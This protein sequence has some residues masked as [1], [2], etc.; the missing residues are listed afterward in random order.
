MKIFKLKSKLPLFLSTGI[1]T[2]SA[3][4]YSCT[5]TQ[6]TS[7]HN[8]NSDTKKTE[9]CS[10]D[11]S[12]QRICKSERDDTEVIPSCLPKNDSHS[13]QSKYQNMKPIAEKNSNHK[14]KY[15]T[16]LK[17]RTVEKSE[18]ML[19]WV[20]V[21]QLPDFLKGDKRS[22][23]CQGNYLE[24]DW[25][26]RNFKGNSNEAPVIAKADHYNY[27]AEES[28]F[29][30]NVHIEQGNRLIESDQAFFDKK[31]NLASLKGHVL[32]R[33]PGILIIGSHGK[34]NT[35][36]NTVHIN[37][38]QYVL[39]KKHIR[40]SA[41]EVTRD[42]NQVLHF[43][44]AVYT[45]AP[46]HNNAWALKAKKMTINPEAGWGSATD[47]T[48]NIANTPVMYTPYI[49]FPVD[50]RRKTGSLYPE[51]SLSNKRGTEYFQPFYINIAPN[52][53]DTI[54][55]RIMTR[56]GFMLSN[57]F[58]YLHADSQGD[59]GFSYLFGKDALKEKNPFYNR[60]RW[61]LFWKHHHQLTKN[62]DADIDYNKSADKN[63]LRDFGMN[64]WLQTDNNAETI[65]QKLQLR[66]QQN[67]QDHRW[68]F[69]AKAHQFQNMVLEKNDAYSRLPQLTL[70]G[71]NKLTQ[72]LSAR[73]L[74]DYT[75]FCRNKDWM[76]VDKTELND[77]YKYNY[78]PGTGL[79]N[80]QGDRSYMEGQLK[81]RI[82]RSYGFWESGAIYKGTMYSLKSL[83]LDEVRK[84]LKRPSLSETSMNH[85]KMFVPSF[86]SGAGLFFDRL[87]SYDQQNYKQTL[88]PHVQYVYTP[89]VKNQDKIP[90]FDTSETIFNYGNLYNINRFN[91]YD[92]I[93]DTNHIAA[94]VT[95][96][97]LNDQGA[98]KFFFGLG[99]IYYL[100]NRIA[101]INPEQ[102][103]TNQNKFINKQQLNSRIAEAY[104]DRQSPLATKILWHMTPEWSLS[105]DYVHN[106]KHNRIDQ[107]TVG[108]N[109]RFKHNSVF[110]IGYS[111]LKQP[112][113]IV[114]TST[115]QNTGKQVNGDLN[116]AETSFA[117]PLNS[118]TKLKDSFKIFG[119]WSYDITN[120][121][122]LNRMTG[123]QADTC[124]YQIRLVYRSYVNTT[125][126]V[127][128][129]KK[130]HGIFLQFVLK[131]LGDVA[132]NN[133][134]TI[135][136]GIKG[137]QPGNE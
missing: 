2:G 127:E 19:D 83:H 117:L 135:L 128:V 21:N 123:I 17:E 44:D 137:Y 129:A 87:F 99:Q 114:L 66:Y 30:G 20:S 113:R 35:E 75:R 23:L 18:N 132:G 110:N 25:S 43:K 60:H 24:P 59:T 120:K 96:R 85:P 73:Y 1:L 51:I 81:Y 38:V 55:P 14:K 5:Y 52:Y 106:L 94:G 115:G 47:A 79:N 97:I 86:Y 92:R 48:L 4:F 124:N 104:Q 72:Q 53:D 69:V 57:Q 136:K 89:Y 34:M 54:I 46:P 12:K 98:E 133:M 61:F 112:D 105:Q 9:S 101:S 39:Q 71:E 126:R 102:I 8:E 78:K 70:N 131:G 49:D 134:N 6:A 68:S 16:T 74:L 64:G 15:N 118:F 91:G 80:A 63:F 13:K 62:W 40:G 67:R 41:A 125:E 95:S 130:K 29:T 103:E 50:K 45:S 111:Y 100:K 122:N 108:L 109:G 58:R 116:V 56:R 7:A 37:D 93:G 3:V 119:A 36:T 27:A 82:D 65:N 26:G 77:S 121:R 22:W 76:Y 42:K 11:Q 107:Y 31:N 32:L 88:E 10:S 33:Q 84:Q 28:T 90:I